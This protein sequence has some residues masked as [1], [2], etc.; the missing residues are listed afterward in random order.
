MVNF[1]PHHLIGFGHL[2][3]SS[4]LTCNRHP[5]RCFIFVSH[6]YIKHLGPG[7]SS[8]KAHDAQDAL[9]KSFKQTARP[10]IRPLMEICVMP[11][12]HLVRPTTVSPTAIVAS[13]EGPSDQPTQM[14]NALVFINRQPDAALSDLRELV[15]ASFDWSKHGRNIWKWKL[16]ST[17]RWHTL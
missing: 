1:M 17:W 2:Q 12:A 13:H 15:C 3:I 8:T 11:T 16:N 9:R 7:R 6:H 14:L 5:Q 4:A 10:T